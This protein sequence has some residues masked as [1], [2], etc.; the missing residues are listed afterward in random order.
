VEDVSEDEDQDFVP[1]EDLLEHSFFF[2]DEGDD[3]EDES[4]Y[5]SEEAAELNELNNEAALNHFNYI[6]I[7]AQ[8][9]AV[10]AEREAAGEKPKRKRHYTGNSART[11]RHHAH[12]RRQLASTGQKF[13]SS[14]F[15]KKKEMEPIT[16][17]KEAG[18]DSAELIK[19]DEDDD[20]SDG[21]D[22]DVEASLKRLF[23]N[24]QQVSATKLLY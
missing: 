8:A 23:P 19:I 1:E 20:L 5:D 10:K 16:Q 24:E 7:E 22:D 6:L 2:V 14:W 12:K 3:T 9:I 17:E 21:E 4:D 11:I 18:A 13:I 15:A